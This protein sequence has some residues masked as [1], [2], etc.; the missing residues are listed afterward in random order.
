MKFILVFL[1]LAYNYKE[2]FKFSFGLHVLINSV[3]IF[4]PKNYSFT[5]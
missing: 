1:V 2:K 4:T 3:N 5:K